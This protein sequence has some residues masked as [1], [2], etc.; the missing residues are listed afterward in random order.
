MNAVIKKWE[1]KDP[2]FILLDGVEDVRNLGA[3][4]RTA[5]CAGAAC[6]LLPNHKAL[7]SQQPL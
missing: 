1:G 6:V 4:V 2:I 3:I 5:E 7:L